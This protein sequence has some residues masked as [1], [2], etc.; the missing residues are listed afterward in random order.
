MIPAPVFVP[1]LQAGRLMPSWERT[2]CARIGM[3][4]VLDEFRVNSISCWAHRGADGLGPIDQAVAQVDAG[5]Q[6]NNGFA[7]AN[8]ADVEALLRACR[9]WDIKRRVCGMRVTGWRWAPIRELYWKV[10]WCYS[11]DNYVQ[12]ALAALAGN[13]A[14]NN[15]TTL[16]DPVQQNAPEGNPYD[17]PNSDYVNA[18]MV[19]PV[20]RG[21][22]RGP[23]S[24][25][26]ANGFQPADTGRWTYA[27][28][29]V[30]DA[31]GGTPSVTANEALAI[32]AAGGAQG[33]PEG[34]LPAWLVGAIQ[35]AAGNQNLTRRGYVY[36][37]G[38]LG[39]AIST[40]VGPVGEE[41]VFL[42]IPA[43]CITRWWVL[44]NHCTVGPFPFPA[45]G[46]APIAINVSQRRDQLA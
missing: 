38:N 11:C 35:G 27:P 26:A 15:P 44:L 28:W 37:L 43:Q 41:H 12:Q 6:A 2:D 29:F 22:T 24:I 32:N 9:T 4:N 25:L 17:F 3:E 16:L 1:A 39:N 45:G 30:G 21:D 8:D 18:A 46:A 36:Q 31:T 14:A 13:N 34:N 23:L 7:A 42:A 19:Q 20:L 5:W 10:A 40:R 33:S